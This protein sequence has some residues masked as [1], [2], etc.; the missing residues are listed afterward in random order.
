M[1]LG[2]GN[3]V[4]LVIR[5]FFRRHGSSL[6][7]KRYVHRDREGFFAD[8]SSQSPDIRFILRSS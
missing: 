2:C 5:C 7:Y 8:S 1:L 6:I 4:S 3:K